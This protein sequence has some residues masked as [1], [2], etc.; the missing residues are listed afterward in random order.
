MITVLTKEECIQFNCESY[1]KEKKFL[2]VLDYHKT[3]NTGK[4]L[5]VSSEQFDL[6]EKKID[7]M[8]VDFIEQENR[9]YYSEVGTAIKN[10]IGDL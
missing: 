1:A 2:E 7:P 5:K 3:N 9:K 6:G 10:L 4:T 8:D